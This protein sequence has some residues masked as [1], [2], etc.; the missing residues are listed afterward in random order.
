MSKLKKTLALVLAIIMVLAM[1]SGCGK[2]KETQGKN[3]EGPS[4]AVT[5]P[6]EIGGGAG[7]NEGPDDAVTAANADRVLHIAASGDTGTLYPLGLSGGF[8]SLQY[9]FYEP[10]YTLDSDGNM[11]MKLAE[12]YEAIEEH[13]HYMLKVRKGVTFSNGNPLT[14]SDIIFTAK[15][16]VDD[17]RFN[18]N[19]KYIDFEKTTIIDDYTIEVY[20]TTPVYAQK[21]AWT[22]MMIM[23]EESFDPEYMTNHTIGTGPYAVTDYVVNSHV[24]ADAR[25]DY[26]G[27]SPAV[28]HIEWKVISESAQVINALEIGDIDYASGVSVSELDY[29]KSLGYDL[30]AFYGGYANTALFSF[31]GLL[32][33]AD[34]RRAVCHA[35]DRESLCQLMYK[36]LSEVPR[37]PTSEH[38]LD[39]EERFAN[40][41]DVYAVGYDVGLAEE[42][43]KK[44]GLVGQTLKIVT[45]GTESFNDVATVLVENLSAIGVN[46]EI[47]SYDSATYFSTIMDET[48]FD[49]ALF[50]LSAPSRLSANIM[51]YLSFIPLGWTDEDGQRYKDMCSEILTILDEKERGDAVY[52]ALEYFEEFNP[53]YA[54][55]EAVTVSAIS[56]DVG[57]IQFYLAGNLYYDDLYWKN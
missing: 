47:V 50:Y 28:K 5:K 2:E 39:F 24:R 22:Q 7:D 53:W 15:L 23:D 19:S 1:F 37:Y 11:V 32:A 49:I 13:Y 41:A 18:A 35:M 46:A 14:A 20:Y 21:T 30:R 38:T 4:E 27:G 12:S 9:A 26:W 29:V 54:I 36:G 56:P 51:G 16:C 45:N 57:G 48:T 25:E 31:N 10:I 3:D 33:N 55:C 34:A 43:A 40:V 52:E 17:P 6:D 42:Y 8:V 44:S